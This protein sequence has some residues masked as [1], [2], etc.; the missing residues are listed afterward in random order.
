MGAA[1]R[2][3]GRNVNR[4]SLSQANKLFINQWLARPP[5][6]AGLSSEP[7]KIKIERFGERILANAQRIFY[8]ELSTPIDRD[9]LN[10]F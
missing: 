7:G 2:N 10:L 6:L 5:E 4:S 8:G 1:P 3:S 9:I